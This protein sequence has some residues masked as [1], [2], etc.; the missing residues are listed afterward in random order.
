MIRLLGASLIALAVIGSLAV[1]VHAAPFS[2]TVTGTATLMQTAMPGFVSTS[3]TGSGDDATYGLFSA[4]STSTDDLTNLPV[5]TITD[6]SVLETFSQGTL[7]AVGSGSGTASGTGVNTAIYDLQITG[8]TG[9]FAGARGEVT[10]D[11]T[12]TI[13]SMTTQSITG[14]IMGS[15]FTVPEPS[16]L[17]LLAPAALFWLYRR[18]RTTM[19]S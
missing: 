16:S 3:F 11:V 14:T 1:P 4:Q 13:T 6:I 5:I 18:R 12:L 7:S 19:V 2:Q 10:A 8:G 15:L 9:V 17:T